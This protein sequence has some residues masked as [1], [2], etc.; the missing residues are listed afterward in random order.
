MKKIA[1]WCPFCEQ[2][3]EIDA[4]KFATQACPNCGKPIRACSLCDHN[5][6]NC[7]TCERKDL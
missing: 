5:K 7:S 2:E 1:E 6:C 3:V 4:I